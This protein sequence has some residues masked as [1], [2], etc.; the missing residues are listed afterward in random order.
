M[1]L[2]TV[3]LA[4]SDEKKCMIDVLLISTKIIQRE[5]DFTLIFG[6]VLG[7]QAILDE[8]VRRVGHIFMTK[9]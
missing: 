6:D 3:G 4:L 9:K 5:I 8:R 2:I 1:G 7:L